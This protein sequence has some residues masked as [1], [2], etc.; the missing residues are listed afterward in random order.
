[1]KK[2][3]L[4][5]L[6]II[7]ISYNYLFGFSAGFMGSGAAKNAG[8]APVA[9]TAY[10][11]L[12]SSDTITGG[13]WAEDS[14]DW[15]V[16]EGVLTINADAVELLL[17]S[18]NTTSSSDN[19]VLV[20]LDSYGT[21][22]CLGAAVRCT[23]SGSCYGYYYCPSD[24]S[25]YSARVSLSGASWDQIGVTNAVTFTS[26]DYIGLSVANTGAANI[27]IS[28][29]KNPS[30]GNCPENWGT[31]DLAFCDSGSCGADNN[32]NVDQT[33]LTLDTGTSV[34]IYAY[35][36]NYTSNFDNA[37]WGPQ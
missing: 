26:G 22:S 31:A 35:P 25:G 13:G 27:I 9:C 32:V 6:T 21:N 5:C 28:V 29:W 17:R 14:G 7:L 10:T 3:V 19:F 30:G 37:S 11:D 36:N 18:T 4:L 1:M 2:I 12:F 34:A 15:T 33:Y 20:E 16:A 23:V 24:N 8:G